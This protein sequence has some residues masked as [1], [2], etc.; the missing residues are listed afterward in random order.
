MPNRAS[1]SRSP[2]LT[3]AVLMCSRSPAARMLPASASV[4]ISSSWRILSAAS[5][6]CVASCIRVVLTAAR[7]RAPNGEHTSQPAAE[8]A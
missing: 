8:S 6:R 5:S 4:L 1:T 2:L 7:D 3:A